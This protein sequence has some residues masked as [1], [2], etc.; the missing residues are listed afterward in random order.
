MEFIMEK[1]AV[2]VADF[3]R[4]VY[5]DVADE[6]NGMPLTV[7]SAL[8]RAGLDP[9]IEAR[10][11]SQLSTLS[12]VA[13]LAKT[14]R[15]LPAVQS[16]RTDVNMIATRLVELLPQSVSAVKGPLRI[17]VAATSLPLPNKAALVV[18]GFVFALSV[19]LLL[20]PRAADPIAPASW[21]SEKPAGTIKAQAPAVQQPASSAAAKPALTSVAR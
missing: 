14:L 4:F 13:G 19:T 21:L 17:G 5:A 15:T 18:M 6:P 2:S 1:S 16:T 10:R 7:I 20:A 12:A 11:L 3:E 9:W 8:S